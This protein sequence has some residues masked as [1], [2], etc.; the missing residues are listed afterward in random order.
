MLAV[1]LLFAATLERPRPGHLL[2]AL[3]RMGRHSL[4]IYWIHVELVYGYATWPVHRKLPLEASLAAYALL[5]GVM[6]GALHL[7][8]R[9]ASAWDCRRN[10]GARRRALQI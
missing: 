1:G 2:C 9:V 8:N 6:Y 10:R 3:E 4:F 5:C 7:R